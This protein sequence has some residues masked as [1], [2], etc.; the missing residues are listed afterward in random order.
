M[1]VAPHSVCII[2]PQ[3]RWDAIRALWQAYGYELG[4]GVEMS[5]TG[6][7]PVTHRGAHMWLTVQQALDF[8]GRPSVIVPA[9]YNLGQVISVL[10]QIRII[11]N[12]SETDHGGPP[13]ANKPSRCSIDYLSGGFNLN[14]RAHFNQVSSDSNIQPIETAVTLSFSKISI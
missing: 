10:Q 12:G 6:N 1:T 7:T 2:A 9:G 11:D 5:P 13:P 3:A 8:T 14:K 4:D